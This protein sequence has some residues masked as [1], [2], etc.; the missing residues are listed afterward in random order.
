MWVGKAYAAGL[1]TTGLLIASSVL[2]LALV[3]GLMAFDGEA[4]SDSPLPIDSIP[5]AP[6]VPASTGAESAPAPVA[7]RR[8]GG[9]ERG[10]ASAGTRPGGSARAP[11]SR[12][13]GAAPSPAPAP[14]AGSGAT[15]P[16]APVTVPVP[17]GA[18]DTV[19]TVVGEVA[20]A[21]AQDAV[22]GATER[23]P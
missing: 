13:P 3:G 17:V 21:P 23:L 15:T 11:G 20:P 16:A 12:R 1:G 6:T 10:R 2:L 7:D 18:G 5:V 8:E 19:G 14:Y 9:T 22:Q 4:G